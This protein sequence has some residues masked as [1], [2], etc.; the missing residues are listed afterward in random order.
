VRCST[1]VNRTS[2]HSI[3]LHSERGRI[4]YDLGRVVPVCAVAQIYGISKDAD[5][6]YKKRMPAQLK[7]AL[8]PIERGFFV[9]GKSNATY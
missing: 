4:G 2:K 9:V 3:E 8:Y 6:R 7:V 5:Y 1:Y